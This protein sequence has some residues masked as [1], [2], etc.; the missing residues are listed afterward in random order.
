MGIKLCCNYQKRAR[1]T[2][3]RLIYK[4]LRLKQVNALGMLIS[5]C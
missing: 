4:N 3:F 2:T 5:E 1:K